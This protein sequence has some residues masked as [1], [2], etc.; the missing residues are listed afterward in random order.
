MRIARSRA[1]VCYGLC[2]SVLLLGIGGC[3]KESTPVSTAPKATAPPQLDISQVSAEADNL[4]QN[5]NHVLSKVETESAALKAAV[6]SFIAEPAQ[7]SLAQ[8][9]S[10]WLSAFVAYRHFYFF[11]FLGQASP[12]QFEKLAS[13]HYRIAANPIQPGYLDA[14]GPYLYS[15]LV[16]DI[17][18]EMNAENLVQQNGLTNSEDVTL[19]LYALHF[20]LFGIANDR[21]YADYTAVNTLTAL[22]KEQGFNS[23]AE[24]PHNRRRALLQLQAQILVEDVRH[25]KYSWNSTDAGSLMTHWQELKPQQKLKV[26]TKTLRQG[27]T[28]LI[29][30]VAEINKIE[31]KTEVGEI[32]ADEGPFTDADEFYYSNFVMPDKK[33]FVELAVKSLISATPVLPEQQHNSVNDAL[34]NIIAKLNGENTS[35]DTSEVWSAVYENLKLAVDSLS[36]V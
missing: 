18:V 30:D 28:Q 36:T 22:D 24:L 10:A 31:N 2:L 23:T 33:A 4:W 8:A 12:N 17:G 7:P 5:G 34:T 9:Q 14:F 3:E 29:I 19:G 11:Y 27:L 1:S 20:M 26:T 35:G 15:G 25:L 16:H 32:P 13:L 21:S 6:D